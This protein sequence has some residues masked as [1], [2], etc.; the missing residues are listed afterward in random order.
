MTEVPDLRPALRTVAGGVELAVFCQP[1]ASRT[2]LIGTHAGMVKVKVR[3]AAIDGKA[4]EALLVLLAAALAIP[5]RQL[6]LLTGEQSRM[7]RVLAEG[8]D[9]EA[10]LARLATATGGSG[11]RGPSG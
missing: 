11:E 10:A 6:R 2:A 7:K 5:R 4:N 3:E 9:E 8:I 1:K